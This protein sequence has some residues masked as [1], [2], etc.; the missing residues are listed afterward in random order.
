MICTAQRNSALR[1]MNNPE[2]WTNRARSA[3]PQCTGCLKATVKTPAAIL[4]SAKYAKKT[5]TI[6]R[7]AQMLGWWLGRLEYRLREVIPI[8]PTFFN[9]LFLIV[10]VQVFFRILEMTL[11]DFI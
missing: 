2:T 10:R 3:K 11:T 1:R 6:D 7:L 4:A 8:F 5:K 9:I